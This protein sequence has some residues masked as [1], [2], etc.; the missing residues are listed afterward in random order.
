MSPQNDSFSDHID[1]VQWISK[2]HGYT[3]PEEL[4][5]MSAAFSPLAFDEDEDEVD[6]D[7]D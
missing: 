5:S 6:F 4:V 1:M 3:S 2:R 7:W